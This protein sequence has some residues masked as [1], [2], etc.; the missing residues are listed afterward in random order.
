MFEQRLQ[1]EG[2][3]DHLLELASVEG[4]GDE[5]VGDVHHAPR[6]LLL[7]LTGEHDADHVRVFLLH[8]S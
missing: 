1:G 2:P 7:G 4:L 3:L 5:L 6:D 8:L